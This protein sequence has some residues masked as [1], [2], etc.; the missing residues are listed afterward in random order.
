VLR[1]SLVGC[2]MSDIDIPKL[3]R[4]A[5]RNTHVISPAHGYLATSYDV[6]ALRIENF[7]SPHDVL[8]VIDTAR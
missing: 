5:W 2:S 3:P 8:L 7:I 1:T 6:V 4:N